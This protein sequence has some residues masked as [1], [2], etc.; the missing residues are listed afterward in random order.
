M[1]EQKKSPL[2]RAIG[3]GQAEQLRHVDVPEWGEKDKPFRVYFR[4]LLAVDMDLL[5]SLGKEGEYG[6]NTARVVAMKALDADGNRLFPNSG[7]TYEL[8][9]KADFVVL[10]RISDAI[11][12]SAPS[13]AQ[14]EKN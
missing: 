1:T 14:A 2:Q 6:T 10:R 12:A 13:E 9:T 11:Q 7:D 5:S 3:H 4:T 8:A